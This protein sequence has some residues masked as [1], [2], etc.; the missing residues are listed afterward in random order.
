MLHLLPP[1]SWGDIMNEQASINTTLPEIYY[2]P[3]YICSPLKLIFPLFISGHL[4]SFGRSPACQI[5]FW[6]QRVCINLIKPWWAIFSSPHNTSYS[7]ADTLQKTISS[8]MDSCS[9]I[10]KSLKPHWTQP[11]RLLLSVTRNWNLSEKSLPWP[12]R[13]SVNR[14]LRH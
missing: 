4:L 10:H 6:Q 9:L 11:L 14:V 7:S 1:V 12:K 5:G 3:L 8:Q 13:W 2:S